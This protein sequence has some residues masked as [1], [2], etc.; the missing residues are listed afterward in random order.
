MQLKLNLNFL[1]RAVPRRETGRA[2]TGRHRHA[3]EWAP[4]PLKHAKRAGPGRPPQEWAPAPHMNRLQV[5]S[6]GATVGRAATGNCSS[7]GR[8]PAH[9]TRVSGSLLHAL[10]DQLPGVAA[11]FLY[12]LVRLSVLDPAVGPFSRHRTSEGPV[13]FLAGFDPETF[14][15]MSR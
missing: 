5:A 6:R 15:F 13:M 8:L 11:T 4:W 9:K 7:H 1:K 10:G 2:S 14:R 12:V 3:G